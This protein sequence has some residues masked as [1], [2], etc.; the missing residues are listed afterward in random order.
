MN[1]I[2]LQTKWPYLRA[3]EL[4]PMVG[5]CVNAI[6]R[7]IKYLIEKG[8]SKGPYDVA[9]ILLNLY[10]IKVLATAKDAKLA[11]KQ[12]ENAEIKF[13]EA[14]GVDWKAISDAYII[15]VSQFEEERS[16]RNQFIRNPDEPAA[17]LQHNLSC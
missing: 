3:T 4:T 15:R 14:V 11:I 13:Q 17:F 2:V 6:I 5:D 16:A 12:V 7:I 1:I 9:D 8:D 10:Y